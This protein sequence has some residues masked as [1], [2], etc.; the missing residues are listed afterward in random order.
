M[1]E[2]LAPAGTIEALKAA[3]H[4]GCNAIYLGMNRFGARAYATNFDY[5]TLKEALDY[6][7]LF[8]VK[9]YVTM[10][11]IVFEE[12]LDEAYAQIDKLY[13]LGVDG[14]II[15]DLALIDYVAKHCPSMEAHASTQMGLDDSYGARF[16]ESIG[17]K[18]VVLGR[19]CSLEQ[20][21][22]VKE[23]TNLPIEV[24]IHGALCVSYSGNCLMSGL[25]GYRSGNRGRCV[26]SCR[27]S[28][29]LIEKNTNTSYGESYIL[30]MKDLNTIKQINKL[31]F[32]DSLKIEGRM[33]EPTYVAN[34]V[35]AYRKA[36]DTHTLDDETLENLEKTFQRTY[37]EGY[38][39][40]EDKKNITNIARPNHNG[41]Y[42]GKITN[43]KKG[44][45]EIS[46]I[47]KLNQNDVIRIDAKE[48]I[49]YPVVKLYDKDKNL[50]RSSSTKAYLSLKEEANIGDKVYIT[51]DTAYLDQLQASMQKPSYRVPLDFYI[52][53]KTN[54][55]LKL[56]AVCNTFACSVE[57]EALLEP[58]TGRLITKEDIYKQLCRLKDTPYKIEHF[59]CAM[60]NVFIPLSLLNELRRN[61][62]E[63]LN[64]KRLALHRAF[65][66]IVEE[67]PIIVQPS[68]KGLA[69]FCTTKDQYEACVEGNIP[70]IY[71]KNYVRRNEAQYIASE[72]IMLVGGYNGINYYKNEETYLVSDFSLNVV[73]SKSVYILHKNNV[74][75]VT[76]SHELNKHDIHKLVEAYHKHYKTSCNL[77]M[78]VYGHAH[79]LNT[80]YCPLKVHNLCGE[81]KK[82]HYAL[83]DSV[84][85]FPI[86]SH[87]DCTTTLINGKILNL[88]DDLSSLPED[89]TT[90]RLQFTI[91]SKE[92]T[93]A[94]IEKA[95]NKLNG[96]AAS[97][98]NKKTDT[99]GHFNRE[100]L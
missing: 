25:I 33:K 38:I 57:S 74:D 18:R 4:S 35:S 22:K 19:E 49:N 93:K 82:G 2:L 31:D 73:N 6:S 64:K 27:K 34:I 8:N 17:V 69:C 77:E 7:H 26:G 10:N 66:P 70:V 98:F 63:D 47:K 90:L 81:C 87:D 36:I 52:E 59:E 13:E 86:I 91:E 84:T 12:E 78:I 28:Y 44:F 41:Y 15:Q 16:V 32:V 100:I 95:M 96:S 23:E 72:P 67:K 53:A 3:I 40:K 61:V 37:T 94:I 99:R 83:K 30:S 60:D 71:Y 54:Q 1:Q 42:V 39:F 5:D 85:E 48:E 92:E 9:I 55:T 62:I 68:K 45:Y 29:E 65:Q 24:F 88:L 58:A 43:T 75:R 97:C 76:L 46:L 51:K 79:L 11:T 80:K 89:I 14:L 50:I 20:T 21:K 56:T